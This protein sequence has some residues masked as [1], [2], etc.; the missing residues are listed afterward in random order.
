MKENK[1]KKILIGGAV[2]I[3]AVICSV[4]IYKIAFA[5]QDDNKI[6]IKTAK[7]E[8]I[9]TGST[10]YD[11]YDGS[12]NTTLDP[13]STENYLPG[14]DSSGLNRIVRSFDSI[15]YNFDF[16]ISAKEGNSDFQNRVVDITVELTEDE[17]KYVSFDKRTVA[18]E[19]S[20]KF[21]FDGIDSMGNSQKSVT[22]YVLGAPN[23]TMINPKF[24][25]KESTD[26]EAGITLGKN[27]ETANN[28]VYDDGTYR[29]TS[30][31]TN[32]MPTVVS[33]KQAVLKSETLSESESQ[34]ATYD[35]KTG[36]YVTVVSG[37]YVE[38]DAYKGIKGLDIPTGNITFDM[39][40][41]QNGNDQ[42]VLKNEWAR[43][44]GANKVEEIEPV[45]VN[46]PYSTADS[47]KAQ[48]E[49]KSAGDMSVVIENNKY[50][51]TIANYNP[52]YDFP[53]LTS[54][55]QE[56]ENKYYIGT[57][58]FTV[59]S[60]RVN[61]DGKNNINVSYEMNS[62]V[63]TGT[64]QTAYQVNTSTGSAIN[65]YY[66]SGDHSFSTGFYTGDKKINSEN[67]VGSLSKGSDVIY[68]TTFNYKKSASDEGIKEV[69]KINPNAFRV[70]DYNDKESVN[71]ELTCDDKKCENI[72]TNDFEIK[73]LT[74]DYKNSNYSVIAVDSRLNEEDKNAIS[75]ACSNL[76]LTA[77]S[78]DQILN[79]YG[80]PC[81]KNI[82][83]DEE[84]YT[85]IN[86]AKDEQGKEKP[87]TKII[88]QTKQGTNLPDNV[89]IDVKVKLRVRNVADITRVYQAAT[90]I[91]SSDYD[92]VLHYYYPNG[93]SVVDPN[94]YTLPEIHGNS[95]INVRPVAY[96]DSIRIANYTS[97][98]EIS[99]LNKTTDGKMKT[100][101]N[102]SEN[103]T[104]I[105][106]IKPIITDE[107]EKVGADDVWFVKYV[108][109]GVELPGELE[110]IPDADTDKYLV[111]RYKMGNNT[112]LEYQLPYTKPNVENSGIQFKTKLSSMIS[113]PATPVVV[114]SQMRALNVNKE[115]DNSLFGESIKEFTIYAN[116]SENVFVEQT[117][118]AAGSIVEKNTE[119]S[120][121]LK[122]YNNTTRIVNDYEIIDI[123]PSNGD[124]NGS[125]INGTYE[126]KLNVP[127][128]LGG[129]KI[130]CSTQ[131]YEELSKEIDS[132]KNE[133]TECSDITENYK[134]VTAI[135]VAEISMQPHTG[136]EAIEVIIK[137]TNNNYSDKYINDFIGGNAQYSKNTSN[138]IAINVVGRSI[139]GKVFNDI[140]E[141]GVQ[142]EGDKYVSNVPVTLYKVDGEE[143]TKVAESTTNKDGRYEFK[144]LDIGKYYIDINYDGKQ[145]DL[146]LRYA[147]DNETIDSDAYKVSDTVA[148]ISNKRTPDDPFGIRLTREITKLEN[149]DMGLIPRYSFG[150]DIKK[151]ITKT[152][153]FYKG[154]V[155]VKN[156]NNLS[157]VLLDIRNS[158][159]ATAKVYYGI[160]ITNNSVTPGYVTELEESIPDGLVFDPNEEL[161]KGWTMVNGKAYS[162]T[163]DSELIK[164]GE[165]KYLQ[166]V[167]FMPA[168]E[169]GKTFIN[170]VSIADMAPYK[171]NEKP[172]ESEYNNSNTY[173]IGDSID[174]AGL[175]WHVINTENMDDGTQDITLLADSGSISMKS[176]HTNSTNDVYKWADSNINSSLNNN[177][178]GL[179]LDYG[180]LKDNYVCNDASGLDIASYGGS[181]SGTC[182]SGDFV[183]SK[184]RL[185][186]IEEYTRITNSSLSNIEWLTGSQPYWLES[187][188]DTRPVY[189][190]YGVPTAG[191]SVYNKASYVST[192]GIQSDNA[193][194]LKEVRPVIKVNS[195]NIL[196]E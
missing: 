133:W 158:Q 195:R 187:T 88:I 8:S 37:L 46:A 93:T 104:I 27:T 188:D 179:A 45:L 63:S 136:T 10:N 2:F 99:V 109:I 9:I 38:G 36:R 81:V 170:T 194:A 78:N 92:T 16:L 53:V 175:G 83:T 163:L 33:S 125:V 68:K 87:I 52:T 166:I 6:K 80:S 168:R 79:I 130:Y 102:T 123:L 118:G 162:T 70:F 116:G 35:N 19:T 103:E 23:G 165:T 75:T 34:K 61:E 192:S 59:F 135:R 169:D 14:Y 24:T 48:K 57:Y 64:N 85:K 43:L 40:L 29:S 107:N 171:P 193:S 120:Y 142:D 32:Y 174:Y 185:L 145:Y 66:Q 90:V 71:I 44:Y 143:H 97:D 111:N 112:Y 60:P 4:F 160:S 141:N 82:S 124:T 54:T 13:S 108:G 182:Q 49:I 151:Y 164:P 55:D 178:Y 1:K 129:A 186:T 3:I 191:T 134:S 28:Y 84:E 22:L 159:L 137:P 181:I 161:N 184:V 7:I 18:G 20:H 119:F 114:R 122:V 196:F 11:Q 30:D 110:F 127:A 72:N 100:T 126:V 117:S 167:L 121:L 149:Y 94:N 128:S 153:L 155:A 74:G 51:T 65:E 98:Q 148:R 132:S 47:N 183:K 147:S 139:S 86:D 154:S 105:Y 180:I 5:D 115:V 41:S 58:A 156:Y 172:T 39:T 150:F 50:K 157:K 21:S 56:I 89:T 77:L 101:F 12:G 96:A 113:E 31:F 62:I 17:A 177:S 138:K 25:I 69:I 190:M 189:D 106:N 144:N 176:G 73:F 67:K 95:V 140:N 42:L 26:Q 146:T 76:N 15:T 173:A 131:K 91:S 152:E